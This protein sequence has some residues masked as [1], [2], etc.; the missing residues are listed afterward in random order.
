MICWNTAN[1]KAIINTGRGIGPNSSFNP[2][3]GIDACNSISPSSAA[4][5]LGSSFIV[6]K[7]CFASATLPF[8]TRK[9]GDSGKK[10]PPT[11]N[12]AAGIAANPSIQ[13]QPKF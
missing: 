4:T 11:N 2:P 13:C 10:S 8:L 5:N 1:P 6:S 9:R 3:D 7:T 12:K